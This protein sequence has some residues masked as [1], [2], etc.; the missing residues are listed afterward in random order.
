MNQKKREK[1][2]SKLKKNVD[3]PLS[4]LHQID[5][6]YKY[7]LEKGA[8]LIMLRV[9]D[10]IEEFGSFRL[11]LKKIIKTDPSVE[12]RILSLLRTLIDGIQ[13][14]YSILSKN[15]TPTD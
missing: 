9:L 11:D 3:D 14:E 5:V 15:I 10:N 1:T 8:L 2:K 13:I 7:P 12:T 6:D 4:T